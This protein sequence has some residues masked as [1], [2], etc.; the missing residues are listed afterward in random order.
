[1]NTPSPTPTLPP[2]VAQ[3]VVRSGSVAGGSISVSVPG[4]FRLD[5]VNT[6]AWQPTRWFD[7]ATSSSQDLA[8]KGGSSAGYNGLN[9]PA[10]IL[11]G[12][13]WYSLAHA[14]SATASILEETPAR[15]TLRTQYHIRP[16]G[17]D[18]LVQTDYTIYASG[19][20][21]A[22]LTIQNQSGSSETL[23]TVE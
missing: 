13:A 23:D 6:S 20:V 12:G 1:T 22:S 11:F 5:F 9:E 8:N 10:E 18:F 15:V 7:L 2:G 17:A 19:R 14:Q 4:Q 21:A 16:A 3:G